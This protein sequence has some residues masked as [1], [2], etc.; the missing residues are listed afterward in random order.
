LILEFDSKLVDD[1]EFDI[2]LIIDSLIIDRLI[3]K[4]DNLL[5]E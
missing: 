5:F 3:S 1:I 2:K 4:Y